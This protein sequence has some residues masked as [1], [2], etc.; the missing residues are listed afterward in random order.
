MWPWMRPFEVTPHWYQMRFWTVGLQIRQIAYTSLVSIGPA[1]AQSHHRISLGQSYFW[2]HLSSWH[3]ALGPKSGD[4]IT[5]TFCAGYF[6]SNFNS[7]YVQDC[8][9]LVFFLYDHIVTAYPLNNE[10]PSNCPTHANYLMVS[11]LILHGM[12]QVCSELYDAIIFAVTL[13]D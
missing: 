4:A 6:V 13:L 7:V 12:T 8:N 10:H 2:I 11:L 9:P 3:Q 5:I 1:T